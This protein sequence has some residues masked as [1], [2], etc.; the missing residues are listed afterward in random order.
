[1]YFLVHFVTE[2][3]KCKRLDLNRGPLVSDLPSLQLRH[4]H[5]PDLVLLVEESVANPNTGEAIIIF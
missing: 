3:K 1:M 5:C 2:N 4:S